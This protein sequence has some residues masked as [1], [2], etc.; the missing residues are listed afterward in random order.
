[1]RIPIPALVIHRRHRWA[2]TRTCGVRQLS[3]GGRGKPDGLNKIAKETELSRMQRA[4]A[5]QLERRILNQMLEAKLV[6][7]AKDMDHPRDFC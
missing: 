7:L 5:S 1:M 3:L 4:E 6:K 2:G